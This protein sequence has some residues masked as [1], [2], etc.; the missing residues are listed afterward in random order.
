MSR[1]FIPAPNCASVEMIYSWNA[2][3]CEN[4]FHVRKSSPYS[5]ADL[6]ALRTIFDTWDNTTWK[7]IR[8]DTCNLVRF[9]SKALDSLGSPFEDYSLP[10]PRAGTSSAAGVPNSV[11]FAVKLSTGLTGRSYRGRIYVIGQNVSMYGA[12]N[13][14]VSVTRA[15][16]IVNNLNTLLA[17]LAAGGHTLG[18][19]SWQSNKTWRTSGLFTP[20]TGWAYTDLNIDNQRRRL[21][22]RGI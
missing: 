8:A 17:N 18:V 14:Q 15:T 12:T 3:V 4:V 11:T 16:A 6:A 1:P 21:T 9:R 5:A 7:G 13:N 22:G 2:V 20:A 10:S 19:M